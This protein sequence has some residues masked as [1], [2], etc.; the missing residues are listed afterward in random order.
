M[1][2]TADWNDSTSTHNALATESTFLSY[3]IVHEFNRPAKAIVT[4]GDK[5]GTI[6][7]KYDVDAAGDSVYVG[8]GRAYIEDPTGTP[9]F[10]GRIVRA[11]SDMANARLIL[12][13]EDWL[14]QLDDDRIDYDMRE[15]LNGSG[16]RQSTAHTDCDNDVDAAKDPAYHVAPGEDYMFDDDM[17][18]AADK[19]NTAPATSN[20][21]VIVFTAGMAGEITVGTG[22]YD[23]TVAPATDTN[24]PADGE[25]RLW[26]ADE[27][28]H[29][30]SDNDADYT[31]EY[32]FKVYVGNNTPSDFYVH[33][34]ITGA[35]II[36]DYALSDDINDRNCVLKLYD[37]DA[38][39]A[40]YVEV[41][42]LTT[43][44]FVKHVTATIPASLLPWVVDTNGVVKVKLFLT[45]TA[46]N[47]VTILVDKIWVE[48]DVSTTGYS[49]TVSISDTSTNYV[50]VGTNLTAA[51]TRIWE[52]IP[53]SIC[54]PIYK[55]I[56]SDES[57]GTLVTAGDLIYAMT[58]AAN[59]EHTTS[60]SLR[61]FTE[62]TRLEILTDLAL[63]D[64]AVFYVPLGTVALTWKSTFNDGAPTALTDVSVLQ[65]SQGDWNW[66]SVFNECHVYGARIADNQLSA[67][68]SDATSISTY[69]IARVKVVSNTGVVSLYDCTALAD[70]EVD[71][72][73]DERLYLEAELGGLS[74]LRLGSEVNITS[75]YLGLTN[76]KYTV[77]H[78]S[79]DSNEY[80]TRIR[81]HPRA[82]GTGY[83]DN[84]SIA[85]LRGVYAETKTRD[86]DRY[87][88]K[89]Y[90]DTWS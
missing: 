86:A 50:R 57:P 87:I 73:K 41:E 77:T 45:V 10:D 43:C 61:H 14:S 1:F 4:L 13:C 81:L 20:G 5:D 18:W 26:T 54:K 46:G 63:D 32:D 85:G 53:Y 24:D 11:V 17:N 90:T 65:W 39:V 80:R 49:S 67:T 64:A 58:S 15:D 16:L 75:T 9:I 59:V 7:K 55:H 48:V 42:Q 79:F 47:T 51:A 84:V 70:Q 66:P 89:P 76:T 72:N 56:D 36:I 38:G 40:D 33:G 68:D 44:S 60:L 35:R 31:I 34:S 29:L 21:H 37:V 2:Q 25:E 19:W 82:S 62:R 88:P 28:Y 74:A 6:A 3:R 52:G 83:Q 12:E 23:E 8:P 22:P 78:W 69:G 30:V 71:R 27:S